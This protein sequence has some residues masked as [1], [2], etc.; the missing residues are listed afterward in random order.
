MPR[1]G[2]D[3]RTPGAGERGDSKRLPW[4]LLL[5]ATDMV[6]ARLRTRRGTTGSKV[7]LVQS[8]GSVWRRD[9]GAEGPPCRTHPTLPAARLLRPSLR[10]PAPGV[11]KRLFCWTPSL[12]PPLCWRTPKMQ[13]GTALFPGSRH[14]KRQYHISLRTSQS[15]LRRSS[16]KRGC[17]LTVTFAG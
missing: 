5:T 3:P 14:Q 7:R 1:T 16:A 17:H 15:W 10:P 8:L 13:D 4:N 11:S 12:P 6:C 2:G 9:P